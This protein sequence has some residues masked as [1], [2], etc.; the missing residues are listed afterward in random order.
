MLSELSHGISEIVEA[1]KN[2]TLEKDVEKD[3]NQTLLCMSRKLREVAN[4]INKEGR[5]NQTRDDERIWR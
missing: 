1:L 4:A 5:Q 3:L 2:R